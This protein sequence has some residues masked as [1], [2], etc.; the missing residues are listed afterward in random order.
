MTNEEAFD[1]SAAAAKYG[2]RLDLEAITHSGTPEM[3]AISKLCSTHEFAHQIWPTSRIGFGPPWTAPEWQDSG[4][5]RRRKV[6]LFE[7]IR[8][9]YAAGETIQALAK[10][11]G[12]HRRVVRQAIDCAIPPERKRSERSKPKLGPLKDAIDAMLKTDLDAPRK[13]RHTAHRVFTRHRTEYPEQPISESQVRR[14]VRQR[15]REIGLIAA[16]C[17]VPQSYS[18]G[19]EARVDWYEAKVKLGGVAQAVSTVSRRFATRTITN[20]V[21]GHPAS[22]DVGDRTRPR[23]WNQCLQRCD[24]R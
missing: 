3:L 5:D 18:F 15:K 24:A 12:V 6:E 9:G 2:S 22:R 1:Q 20:S 14:Y 13:Q 10:K 11:H 4:M 16:D 17:F 21:G 7:V 8:R 23:I 19:Q